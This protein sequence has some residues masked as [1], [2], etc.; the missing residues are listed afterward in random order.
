MSRE[1]YFTGDRGTKSQDY[2]RKIK[3]V[4]ELL[5]TKPD[6]VTNRPPVLCAGCAHRAVF[7]N[8]KA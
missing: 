4:K 7:M 3:G 5:P 2:R 6:K 1:G 8:W